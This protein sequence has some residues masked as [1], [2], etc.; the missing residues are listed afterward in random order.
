MARFSVFITTIVLA[1]L[2]L[3]GLT[4][5]PW[6]LL[7]VGLFG[8]LAALGAYDVVQKKH[9]IL[10][11]YPILGHMRFLFEGIRPEIR[12][13]LIEDDALRSLIVAGQRN[14]VRDFLPESVAAR[15][16]A[17]LGDLETE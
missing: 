9:A 6:F 16:R 17:L 5:S 11:N 1:L 3:A 2:S 8:F 13:Y 14:R 12:Q 4:L 7:G 10:R 15:L